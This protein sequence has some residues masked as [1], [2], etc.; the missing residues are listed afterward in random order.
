MMRSK[1]EMLNSCF[2]L[3]ELVLDTKKTGE[4]VNQYNEVFCMKQT[5][6]FWTEQQ[7]RSVKSREFQLENTLLSHP[8]VVT[9]H[10]MHFIKQ[11]K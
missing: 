4:S 3:M 7:K 5:N 10:K 2:I 8:T 9:K 6:R 11:F 1:K